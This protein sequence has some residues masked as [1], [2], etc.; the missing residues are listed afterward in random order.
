MTDPQNGLWLDEALGPE[1]TDALAQRLADAGAKDKKLQTPLIPEPM[2][3]AAVMA[4]LKPILHVDVLAFLAESWRT[5]D[6]IR[7]ARVTDPP[8]K[9]VIVKLAKH[10]ITRELKP[11]IEVTIGAPMR[12]PLDVTIALTGT[13]DG[14]ALS[15]ASGCV[16]S[17][18][19]GKCDLA[20]QVKLAGEATLEKPVTLKTW[21]LPGEHRFTP[22]LSI[23]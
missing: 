19:A 9:P 5:A 11:V 21:K 4:A 18:G 14:L 1:G 10:S 20:M 16:Q 6:E 15:I 23:P 17:V 8:D 12:V 13:F 22:P 2:L 7:A 3:R